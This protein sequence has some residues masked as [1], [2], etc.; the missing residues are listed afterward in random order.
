MA[1]AT[2][3]R[4]ILHAQCEVKSPGYTVEIPPFCNASHHDAKHEK[5]DRLVAKTFRGDSN[6]TV[7]DLERI[8]REDGRI[9]ICSQ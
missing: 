8:L 3:H 1:E 2:G 5:K 4:S 7:A 9:C 6:A